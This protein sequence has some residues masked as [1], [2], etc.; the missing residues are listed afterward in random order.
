LSIRHLVHERFSRRRILW[1]R[2][3]TRPGSPPNRQVIVATAGRVGST[4][5]CNLLSGV[6]V[7]PGHRLLPGEYLE[8]N[9][10]LIIDKAAVALLELE[11]FLTWYKSHSPPPPDYVPAEHPTVRFV[12]ILRDPRDMLVSAADY[13]AWLDT[14]LGGKGPTFAALPESD[15]IL[16]LIETG[17]WFLES[18]ERWQEWP[19]AIQIHYED[20]SSDPKGTFTALLDA[21]DLEARFDAVARAVRENDFATK[22]GRRAGVESKGSFLRKGVVGDWRSKFDERCLERFATAKDGRWRR[23]ADAVNSRRSPAGAGVPPPAARSAKV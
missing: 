2:V 3:R 20:L 19:H 14:G 11:P 18:L 9:N 10:T 8:K 1:P 21:C 7:K 23:L 22:T 17:D 4:W 15:R 13:L 16:E 12:T 5:T 6:G